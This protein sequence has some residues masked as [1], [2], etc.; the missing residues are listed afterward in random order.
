MRVFGG[1]GES[2][3]ALPQPAVITTVMVVAHLP[4]HRQRTVRIPSAQGQHTAST[5]PA[6]RQH[7]ANIQ[8]AH[9]QHRR[10]T[11]HTLSAQRQHTVSIQP[12]HHSHRCRTHPPCKTMPLGKLVVQSLGMVPDVI[13]LVAATRVP[14]LLARPSR[15]VRGLLGVEDIPPVTRLIYL[16]PHKTYRECV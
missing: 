13:V 12:A 10:H 7:K 4:A 5:P 15:S 6:Y 1:P 8:P 16:T 14:L 3:D 2:R 9:R 11:A